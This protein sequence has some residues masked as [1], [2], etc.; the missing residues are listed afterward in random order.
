M[1]QY[2]QA[3]YKLLETDLAILQ[4]RERRKRLRL[5]QGGIAED[6]DKATRGKNL[7]RY[8]LHCRIRVR[9][10]EGEEGGGGEE[11]RRRSRQGEGKGEG[12]RQGRI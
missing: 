2:C 1:Q 6:V 4:W 5:K 3:T 8:E 9:K 10:E 12:K 11:G 7:A